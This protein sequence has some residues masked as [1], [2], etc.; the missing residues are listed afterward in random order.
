MRRLLPL[1]LLA[2][3]AWGQATLQCGVP[4]DSAFGQNNLGIDGIYSQTFLFSASAGDTVFIRPVNG[5]GN[6]PHFQL[7]Y[8][9]SDPFG[10]SVRARPAAPKTDTG[11]KSGITPYFLTLEGGEYDLASDGS[12]TVLLKGNLPGKFTVEFSRTN[13]PCSLATLRCGQSASGLIALTGQMD[14]YQYAGHPGDVISVRALKVSVPSFPIDPNAAPFLAVYGPDGQVMLSTSGVAA[15]GVSAS[16][17]LSLINVN[18]TLEGPITVLIFEV[19]GLRGGGYAISATKLNGGCGGPTVSCGSAADGQVTAALNLYSFSLQ[20]NAGDVYLLRVARSTTAGAF[21]AAAEIYDPNGKLLSAITP[22]SVTQH[23]LAT[24]SATFPN[25]GTYLVL[26]KGPPDSSTGSFSLSATL[27]NRPC[28]GAPALACSAIVDGAINGLLRT[29]VYSLAASAGDA[30][31]LRLLHTDQNPS[32]R[33]RVD[34]YDGQGNPVAFLNTSNLG[35]LN[36]IALSAGT[37][38]LVLT[39]SFDYSQSGTYSMSVLRL[40]RPCNSGTLSCGAPATSSFSRSLQSSVYSYTASPGDSFTVRI[41]DTGSSLQP[42]VEVYDGQ[43]NLASQAAFGNLASVD[44]S[45][46]A[47]GTYTVVALDTNQ[48]PVAG[49]FFLDLLRTRNAC[50]PSAPIGQTVTGTVS[51]AE[52]FLSYTFAL[53]AG[54]ALSLRSAAFTPGFALQMELYDPDGLRLDSGT[55]GISRKIATGG[56]Y[57]ALVSAATPR[58]GGAYALSWQLLNRPAGTSA[59]ECGGSTTASL[60]AASGFRYYTAAANAGDTLRMIFTRISSNF[61]PQIEIF[62]PTGLRVAASSDIT[63]TV[64]ATGNYLVVVSPSTSNGEVGS[65]TIAYQRPNNPCSPV[66][67]TCGQTALRQVSIPG[68]LDSFTFAGTGADQ[69]TIRLASRSGSYSPFVEMYN[70][71][72]ARLATSS[73]GTLRSVLPL[74]GNYLL[75]VRDRG[76]VNLGSYRVSVQDDSNPCPVTDTEAPT[77]TLLHPTGGEV[78]PGGTTYRIQ[79]QSDDNIG[80]ANHTIA[81]STDAG[82]TFSTTIAGGLNGNT[83]VYDWGLAPDIAPSRMAVVRITATDAA[84]NAQ[85]ATSDLLT[86]IGSGFTPN[87]TANFT[88]DSLN[89]LT[90]AALG[91]GRTVQYTW[92]AAGN[93]VQITVSGQ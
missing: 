75:L 38:T 11:T 29:S 52:P 27:Q 78:L 20:A 54:D 8:A 14:A 44:V 26:V 41:Q 83:Q 33:P 43:G 32:F 85:S 12:F 49:S 67:L 36:F 57:T 15:A 86:L 28:T 17:P 2:A 4:M 48:N 51:G 35:R 60:S 81:L 71:A 3:G 37:Y 19:S 18:V 55:F 24:G 58:T 64:N 66:A 61:S 69:T 31:L 72:G 6:D 50:G 30:F 47:G 87:S 42:G 45:K 7:G 1:L 76:A 9:V 59:L 65:Y 68:Q 80:V 62:D 53:T 77:I 89:R 23:A 91:D 39:D 21:Y 74:D 10:N 5:P 79:W 73:N 16:Q 25:P 13:R 92:D 90:Q 70:A 84:G 46:P 22:N 88:Y 63:Q 34:I 82:K 93:L 40:N 56:N